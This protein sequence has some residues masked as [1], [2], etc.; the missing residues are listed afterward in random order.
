MIAG[1]ACGNVTAGGFT[2]EATVIVSGD[3]DTLS[4]A[5]ASAPA[6]TGPD[7]GPAASSHDEAEGEVEV[8]FLAFLVAEGGAPLQLGREEIR[9]RVDLRGR[10]EAD[11]VDRQP[12]PATRYSELRLV[13]TE[14]DAEVEGLV[15]DGE[16]VTEVRVELEDLSL[17]VTRPLDLDVTPGS[18][19]ELVVDLN[20]LA[21]LEAVDPLTGTV[22]ES[23]FADLVNVVIR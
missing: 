8:E 22:D 21:W 14:I 7:L 6:R 19:A 23:V 4:T 16:P 11:V 15:I 10:T 1:A 20:T 3:A 18:T 17:L 13:F 9:V 5:A 2:G 12:I